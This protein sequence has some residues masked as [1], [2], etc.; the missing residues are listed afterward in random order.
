MA[1]PKNER[2]IRFTPTIS[3]YKP[4]GL[5][6]YVAEEIIMKEEEIEALKL[7]EVDNLPQSRAANRMRI[8]QPTFSRI[9][10]S[11]R[12]KLGD[13]IVNG[14]TIKIEGGNSIIN[15]NLPFPKTNRPF[16]FKR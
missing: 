7:I 16:F 11:S 10:N 8:S 3:Y 5:L 1:R 2:R 13:A 15:E 9:L 14:K 12:K 6:D 4:M